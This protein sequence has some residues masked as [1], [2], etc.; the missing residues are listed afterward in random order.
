MKYLDEFYQQELCNQ[1]LIN[2]EKA[3]EGLGQL[4]FMEVCGTHTMS[5]FRNGIKDLLP[6]NIRLLSGPGCP[7]CV[8]PNHYI[9]R[10]IALSRLEDVIITTFGDMIKVPG[11]SSSL[12]YEKGEGRNIVTV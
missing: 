8:T 1:L 12:S 10:A 6:D 9:D 2:I 7:V 3:A 5:I 11:S 4:T